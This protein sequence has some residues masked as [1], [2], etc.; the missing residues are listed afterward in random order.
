M[1]IGILLQIIGFILLPGNYRTQNSNPRTPLRNLEAG[2][3]TEG[4][5][6]IEKP[7]K[8]KLENLKVPSWPIWEKEVSTFP[9]HYDDT[10]TCFI[11]E[12]YVRVEPKSGNPV[13]FGPGDLVRFPKGM[14]CTWKISKPVR[15]HYKFGD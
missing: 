11:L 12:G 13:E 6:K 9:W 5:I 1:I 4:E 2:V 15:K 10:E 3:M 14:D 8:D 7:S